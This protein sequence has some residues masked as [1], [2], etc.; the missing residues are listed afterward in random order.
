MPFETPQNGAFMV[1][2]YI[3]AAVIYLGYALSL[4]RRARRA[5]RDAEQGGSGAGRP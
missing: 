2:A 1:A 4:W 5:L 3:V